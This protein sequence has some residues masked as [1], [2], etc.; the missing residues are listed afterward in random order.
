[1]AW[2]GEWLQSGLFQWV[3]LPLLIFCARI[4]DVTLGTLRIIFIARGLRY[5]AP[6]IGF[7]ATG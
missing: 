5:W 6:L 7:A 1:M 3:G 2:L 4:V